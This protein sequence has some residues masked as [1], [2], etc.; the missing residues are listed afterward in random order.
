MDVK[1]LTALELHV[2][3]GLA[4]SKR[5][6][7]WTLRTQETRAGRR[8]VSKGLAIEVEGG[9]VRTPQGKAALDAMEATQ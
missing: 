6:P 4:D 3:R 5:E 8:L 9:F 7:R 2:L 1:K